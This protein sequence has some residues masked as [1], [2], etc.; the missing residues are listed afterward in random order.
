M[1]IY[2]AGFLC[3]NLISSFFVYINENKYKNVL[4]T[5]QLL[6]DIYNKFSY[7]IYLDNRH[8]LYKCNY[9]VGN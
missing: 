7:Y 2:Y 3:L 1:Y 6:A 8:Q 4:C 9:T 5:I